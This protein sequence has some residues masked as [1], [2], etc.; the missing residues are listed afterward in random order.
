MTVL[1]IKPIFQQKCEYAD[2]EYLSEAIYEHLAR[3]VV[4]NINNVDMEDLVLGEFEVLIN[5]RKR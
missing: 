4:D 3:F 5:W 1:S 2:L